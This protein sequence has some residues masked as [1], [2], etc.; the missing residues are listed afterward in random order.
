MKALW[1]LK[2]N[3]KSQATT[4]DWKWEDKYLRWQIKDGSWEK[5]VKE[6]ASYVFYYS[7]WKL[8]KIFALKN[9]IQHYYQNY[10]TNIA[11]S[12]RVIFKARN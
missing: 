4:V 9:I 1:K 3:D 6:V 10:Q 8:N 7:A 5:V 2:E 11:K 12:N